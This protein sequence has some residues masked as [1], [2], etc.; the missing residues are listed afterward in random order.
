MDS[1]LAENKENASDLRAAIS[2]LLEKEIISRTINPILQLVPVEEN[3]IPEAFF[4]ALAK[5]VVQSESK[6][7]TSASTVINPGISHGAVPKEVPLQPLLVHQ[8]SSRIYTQER[9][10]NSTKL[11]KL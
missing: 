2:R 9:H 8:S 11:T 5:S 1:P 3:L 4:V 10:S 6:K 7:H